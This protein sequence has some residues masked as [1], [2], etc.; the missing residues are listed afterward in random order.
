MKPGGIR[1]ASE[2]PLD[3]QAGS[4]SGLASMASTFIEAFVFKKDRI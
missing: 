3:Q 2:M 4:S 1:I